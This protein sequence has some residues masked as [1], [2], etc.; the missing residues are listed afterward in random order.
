MVKKVLQLLSI[1][2]SMQFF[3]NRV[4]F[5]PD[6]SNVKVLCVIVKIGD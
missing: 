4:A 1:S 5:A 2:C 6:I 3:T